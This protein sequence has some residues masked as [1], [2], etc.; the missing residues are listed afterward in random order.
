MKPNS[1]PRSAATERTR[2]IIHATKPGPHPTN[3]HKDQR[4]AN[5]P[6]KQDK[7]PKR[8]ATP[9]TTHAP[10][11]R[12]TQ[13]RKPQAPPAASRAEKIGDKAN[14]PPKPAEAKPQRRERKNIIPKYKGTKQSK[15]LCFCI[16]ENF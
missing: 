10:P 8:N 11:D 14:K 9:G 2:D 5:T 15:F 12:H 4:K 7:P 13:D 6:P 3:K 1:V 16:V